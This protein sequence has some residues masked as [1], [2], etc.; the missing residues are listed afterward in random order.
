MNF[1]K[2]AW[3]A[4]VTFLLL[5]LALF[6]LTAPLTSSGPLFADL[7]FV[8]LGLLFLA[9]AINTMGLHHPAA[10]KLVSV[11]YVCAGCL[12]VAALV[13]GAASVVR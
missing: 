7:G 4:V 8:A 13:P 12:V 9:T 1:M 10:D 6:F 5:V 2:N 3:S 11:L